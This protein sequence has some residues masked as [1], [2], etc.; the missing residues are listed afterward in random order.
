MSSNDYI[1]IKEFELEA[2]VGAYEEERKRLQRVVIDLRI[3][4]DLSKAGR[5]A[6]LEDTICYLT[7]AS[8]IEELL[9]SREWVLVEEVAR[10]VCDLIFKFSPRVES[11]RAGVRKFVIPGAKY[12]GVEIERRRGEG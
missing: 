2:R 5:T 12:A 10:A 4:A 11:V 9:A 3:E 1:I 7:L 6:N 8:R